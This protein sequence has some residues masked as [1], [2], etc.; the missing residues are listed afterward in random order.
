MAVDSTPAAPAKPEPEIKTEASSSTAMDVDEGEVDPLEA[1]MMDVTAE[2][3]KINE[4][5]KKRMQQLKDQP[6]SRSNLDEEEALP[7]PIANEDE[8]GSDPEDILA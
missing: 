3:R 2:A 8:Y 7:E 6:E 4:Q 5:D 1:Y